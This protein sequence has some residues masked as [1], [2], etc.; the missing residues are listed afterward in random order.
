MTGHN[1]KNIITLFFNSVVKHLS[2]P[3]IVCVCLLVLKS[4][5]FSYCTR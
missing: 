1:L 3:L 4:V 5:L 2:K